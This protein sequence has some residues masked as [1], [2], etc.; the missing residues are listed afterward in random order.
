MLLGVGGAVVALGVLAVGV[1]ALR[2]A[3]RSSVQ[4]SVV[5]LAWNSK[6]SVL[7]LDSCFSKGV[8]AVHCMFV[9]R[10]QRRLQLHALTAPLPP[11]TGPATVVEDASYQP[12][13]YYSSAF[14]KE[15][16]LN[17]VVPAPVAAPELAGEVA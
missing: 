11:C 12:L 17:K 7:R 4:V 10:L 2:G 14:S 8:M 15:L 3:G 16:G 5:G 1:L 6:H 9:L 13:S